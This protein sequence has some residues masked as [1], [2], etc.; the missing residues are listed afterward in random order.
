MKNSSKI[1]TPKLDRRSFFDVHLNRDTN[2][3]Y[4]LFRSRRSGKN[5]KGGGL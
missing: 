5:A 2:K 3:K 4:I 1:S